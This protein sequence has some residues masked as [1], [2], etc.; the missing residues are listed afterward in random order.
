MRELAP[1]EQLLK[2]RDKEA[3]IVVPPTTW[4]C[5]ACRPVPR[6]THTSVIWSG[7]NTDGPHGRCADCGQK[8]VFSNEFGMKFREGFPAEYLE[9]RTYFCSYW[10]T[11]LDPEK[12][13]NINWRKN[14]GHCEDCGQNFRVEA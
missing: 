12:G 6:A 4:D 9:K 3:I 2:P 7:P 1:M 14:R 8:Y 10:P 13:I 5:L 11:R